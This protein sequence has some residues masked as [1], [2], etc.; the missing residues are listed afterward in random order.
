[1]EENKK[2][3]QPLFHFSF[4]NVL[5]VGGGLII[6]FAVL[7]NVFNNWL[8][9]SPTEK[10][11]FNL[12]PLVIAYAG[13]LILSSLKKL[14][15]L[16]HMLYLIAGILAPVSTLCLVLPQTNLPFHLLIIP[17][18]VLLLIPAF[19][20][21]EKMP[22]LFLLF[23]GILTYLSVLPLI[24]GWRHPTHPL[25]VQIEMGI[26]GLGLLLLP[27]LLNPSNKALLKSWAYS[28]GALFLLIITLVNSMFAVVAEYSFTA[29][30][31]NFIVMLLL[32][33]LGMSLKNRIILVEVLLFYIGHVMYFGYVHFNHSPQLWPILLG[34]TGL[35]W[36][37]LG[38]LYL[39]FKKTIF[40]KS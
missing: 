1:M 37:V 26:L 7:Y 21:Q 35:G 30:L 32:L 17:S 22:K 6:L 33:L 10:Y 13:G 39:L 5:W 16:K 18:I 20:Y 23:Y 9:F 40:S 29:A 19:I 24:Y 36:I 34:M 14:P 28:F 11:S 27:F 15:I 2:I 38:G 4:E 8:L 12:A 25:E 3:N 31:F